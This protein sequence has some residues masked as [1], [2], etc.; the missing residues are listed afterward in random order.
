MAVFVGMWRRIVF[1]YQI[2]G[3]GWTQ[4]V[5]NRN[6]HVGDE[7]GP[8]GD[9]LRIAEEP[10]KDDDTETEQGGDLVEGDGTQVGVTLSDHLPD[11]GFPR[12]CVGILSEAD[13]EELQPQ[14]GHQDVDDH[15]RH[16]ESHPRGEVDSVGIRKFAGRYPLRNSRWI[17]SLLGFTLSP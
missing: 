9:E 8:S 3:S 17:H 7:F 4:R 11:L 2:P 12:F 14:P 10:Q 13:V 6:L 1:D 5:S 16:V 15:S